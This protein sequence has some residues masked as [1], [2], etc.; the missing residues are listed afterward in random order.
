MLWLAPFDVW[1]VDKRK[2]VILMSRRQLKT[3]DEAGFLLAIYDDVSETE[4][5]FG[6]KVKLEFKR[7]NVRGHFQLHASAW[8]DVGKADERCVATWV[9]EYPTASANRLHAGFYRAAIGIGGA[10]GRAG[11]PYRGEEG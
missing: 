5:L 6:V 10:C 9:G 4:S 8:K 2:G 7:T 1:G 3:D 11:L